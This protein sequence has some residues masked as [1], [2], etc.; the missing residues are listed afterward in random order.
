[1]MA[2]PSDSFDENYWAEIIKRRDW[3]TEFCEYAQ[4]ITKDLKDGDPEFNKWN[5]K[6]RGFFERNLKEG[7]V[8]LATKGPD[9]DAERKPIDT[10]VIHHTS[11]KPGY[12]LDYMNAVQLLNIYAPGYASPEIRK[13]RGL[14]EEMIWSGHFRDGHQSFLGYH[15]LMRMDG[16]FER[17]LDDDKIGWHAGNWDM[18]RRSIGICLDNDYEHQDPD[19]QILAK[20]AEHIRKYYPGKKLIGHCQAREGTSCPGGNFIKGWGPKL[21]GLLGV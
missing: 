1:M 10:V 12:R 21:Q 17:L 6:V 20:L 18:N 5:Y 19:Q 7:Q 15:W 8:T 2:P 14:K 4:E 13:E 11:N 9:L 16:S 3:Y